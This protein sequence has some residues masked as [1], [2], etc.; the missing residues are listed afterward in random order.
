MLKS[1]VIA[2]VIAVSLTQSSFALLP[3][4]AVAFNQ[5]VASVGAD[6]CVKIVA[7]ESFMGAGT[8]TLKVCDTAK[9]QALATILQ[10]KVEFLGEIIVADANGNAVQPEKFSGF[11]ELA[12]LVDTAFQGNPYFTKSYPYSPLGITPNCAMVE[13]KPEVIEVATD[14]IANPY[15]TNAYVAADVFVLFLNADA[16]GITNDLRTAT[17]PAAN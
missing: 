7:P 8:T 10:S 16:G 5:L 11:A 2:S 3:P 17:G 15:S 1:L 6:S 4:G 13:F 12:K 9:A 14:N